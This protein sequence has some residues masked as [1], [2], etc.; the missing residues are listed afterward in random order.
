VASAPL[1]VAR[2]KSYCQGQNRCYVPVGWSNSEI[3]LLSCGNFRKAKVLRL[4]SC[5]LL[6]QKAL[7][8]FALFKIMKKAEKVNASQRKHIVFDD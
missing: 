5:C 4:R 3:Y 2:H 8:M 7:F 6:R 1:G